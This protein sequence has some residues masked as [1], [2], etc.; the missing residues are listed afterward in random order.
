MFGLTGYKSNQK[1][2]FSTQTDQC[3]EIYEG[4]FFPN[5]HMHQYQS[6]LVFSPLFFFFLKHQVLSIACESHNWV[7]PLIY[8]SA[9][10]KTV[11]RIPYS[12]HNAQQ[13]VSILAICL[14]LFLFDG[15]HVIIFLCAKINNSGLQFVLIGIAF[16]CCILLHWR[17]FMLSHLWQMRIL[18][19]D[20]IVGFFFSLFS[21]VGSAVSLLVR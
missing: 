21:S 17:I 18:A 4:L 16:K 6:V 12:L 14:N 13:E 20:L 15:E 8:S 5:K 19:P 10:F 2:Y 3:A 9:R 1:S 11:Y 7:K